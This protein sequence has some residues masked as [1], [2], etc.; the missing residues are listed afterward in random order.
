[1]Y[2]N[3]ASLTTVKKIKDSKTLARNDANSVSEICLITSRKS[4]DPCS[5]TRKNK[6]TWE[7]RRS[8]LSPF[9]VKRIIFLFDLFIFVYNIAFTRSARAPSDCTRV[10]I[11][12]RIRARAFW[13]ASLR[14]AIYK[15]IDYQKLFICVCLKFRTMKDRHV[16]A[17]YSTFIE[18][19]AAARN[20]RIYLNKSKSDTN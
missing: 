17:V 19:R 11:T 10:S 13:S 5:V 3:S 16:L 8:I 20:Y 9:S 15:I 12:Y 2:Y 18:D 1:M 4:Y 7:N 6:T 14:F